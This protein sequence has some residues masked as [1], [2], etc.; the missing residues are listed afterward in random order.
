MSHDCGNLQY[1]SIASGKLLEAILIQIGIAKATS[2]KIGAD[3]YNPDGISRF[4]QLLTANSVV[5]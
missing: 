4:S 1:H 3:N 5:R 2:S